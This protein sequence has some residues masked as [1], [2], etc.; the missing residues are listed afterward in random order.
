DQSARSWT[1]LRQASWIFAAASAGAFLATAVKFGGQIAGHH[2]PSFLGILAILLPVLAVG[3]LSLAASFDLE[4]R[5]HTFED[6]LQY[7][8]R[9]RPLFDAIRSE[10][11]LAHLVLQ[12]ESRLLGE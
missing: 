12:V 2:P 4:A 10:R 5:V 1:R 11:S 7:L 3:A 6:T 9:T 8:R